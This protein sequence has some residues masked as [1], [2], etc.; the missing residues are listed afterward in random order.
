M[1]LQFFWL[2]DLIAQNKDS[3][4]FEQQW[5][6]SLPYEVKNMSII[7]SVNTVISCRE[8]SCIQFW[9]SNFVQGNFVHI[10]KLHAQNEITCICYSAHREYVKM[11]LR[12]W[13]FCA[14]LEITSRKVEGEATPPAFGPLSKS[15]GGRLYMFFFSPKIFRK[16]IFRLF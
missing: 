8:I 5:S 16:S 6:K 2:N 11:K 14:S 9:A 13:K 1:L 4:L 12:A 10:M 3:C 7:T 15:G